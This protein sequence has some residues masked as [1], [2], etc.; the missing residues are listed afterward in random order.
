MTNLGLADT[1]KQFATGGGGMDVPVLTG[2]PPVGDFSGLMRLISQSTAP[3]AQNP[4]L[5]SPTSAI[6]Q[7]PNKFQAGMLDAFAPNE[8]QFITK[9]L[10]GQGYTQDA[11]GKFIPPPGSNLSD[12]DWEQGLLNA[13]ARFRAANPNAAGTAGQ[14]TSNIENSLT[15]F[16]Q[17][18]DAAKSAAME[19]FLQTIQD[20]SLFGTDTLFPNKQLLTALEEREAERVQTPFARFAG[21]PDQGAG[22]VA[23]SGPQILT[24]SEAT[25]AAQSRS[26]ESQTGVF[27]EQSEYAL[28]VTLGLERAIF[29][30]AG[31][32]GGTA[33]TPEGTP[34]LGRVTV[35]DVVTTDINPIDAQMR[36]VTG[37]VGQ[38]VGAVLG[39]VYGAGKGLVTGDARHLLAGIR[40]GINI[41][42]SVG[43]ALVPNDAWEV[44]LE[45]LP[46][47]GTV[48]GVSSALAKSALRASIAAYIAKNGVRG[49]TRD[50]IREIVF[51][52]TTALQQ[53]AV[54]HPSL[55]R[56]AQTLTEKGRGRGAVPLLRGAAATEDISGL[57][58]PALKLLARRL[59]AAAKTKGEGIVIPGAAK[60]KVEDLRTA[61]LKYAADPAAP[62]AGKLDIDELAKTIPSEDIADTTFTV[63]KVEFEGG[64]D[65]FVNNR[66][67]TRTQYEDAI[68]QGAEVKTLER[69]RGAGAGDGGKDNFIPDV[70]AITPADAGNQFVGDLS[71]FKEE[72]SEVVAGAPVA[73]RTMRGKAGNVISGATRQVA[74]RLG[75]NPS[76]LHGS[77][78]GRAVTAFYRQSLAAEQIIQTALGSALDVH[79]QSFSGRMVRAL[80]MNAD[81]LMT[82]SLKAGGG[83]VKRA[84]NDVFSQPD[85]YNLPESQLAF[86]RDYQQVVA[87]MESLRVA[88]GLEPLGLNKRDGWYYIPRQVDEVGGIKIPGR[89]NPHL[90]RTIENASDG[91]KAG[92]RYNADP[93]ST[94]ELHMKTSFQEI[95]EKEL[96]DNVAQFGV[97]PSALADKV[98]TL[99][100]KKAEMHMRRTKNAVA[101]ELLDL[102]RQLGA[103]G[104][105]RVKL[106]KQIDRL[107][108]T[109][110]PARNKA[111]KAEWEAAR[112]IRTRA[113]NTARRRKVAYKGK[114][115]RGI[116]DPAF[117]GNLGQRFSVRLWRGKFFP[118][119]DARL[120]NQALGHLSQ[121]SSGAWKALETS[122]NT[123]RFLSAVGDFAA[124]FIQGLPVL[125]SNPIAWSK[126]TAL[127]YQAFF[128]PSVQARIVRDNRKV[129]QEMARYGVPIG[130]PE[131]FRALERGGGPG[132]PGPLKRR[133]EKFTVGDTP[134]GREGIRA[135]QNVGK[136]TVGRFQASYNTFL[137]H[138]RALLWKNSKLP[139]AE[140]ARWIRNLTGG[141]DSR[142]LGVTAGQRSAESVWMAF[143]PR[144]LRSTVA[145]LLD[146]P[147]LNTA[148]G[149]AAFKSLA[150]TVAAAGGIYY[151]TGMA[152]GKTT[153]EILDG[154]NPLEGKKFMAHQVNGDWIGVGGQVRSILQLLTNIAA[155]PDGLLKGDVL[156]NP[157]FA[158]Y[159]SRGA[160]GTA[161]A[162]ATIEGV[163]GG[164]I[165]TLPFDDIDSLPDVGIHLFKSAAPFVIQG[166]MDGESAMSSAFGLAGLR[167]SGETPTEVLNRTLVAL[168]PESERTSGDGKTVWDEWKQLD[169]NQKN[170]A[171]ANHKEIGALLDER[172]EESDSRPTE[173]AEELKARRVE[174]FTD[175]QEN[176]DGQLYREQ[177]SRIGNDARIQFNEATLNQDDPEDF[178]EDQE[179]ITRYFTQVYDAV[180]Q[181]GG[182]EDYERLDQ[183]DAQF[184]ATLTPEEDALIDRQLGTSSDPNYQR[185]KAAR[186]YLDPYWGERDEIFNTFWQQ[187]GPAAVKSELSNYDDLVTASEDKTRSDFRELASLVSQM[188]QGLAPQLWNIRFG[189]ATTDALLYIYGYSDFVV[190]DDAKALVL[191]WGQ[192]NGV[193]FAVPPVR[194]R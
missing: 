172:R 96:S 47:V 28:E 141:L 175:F 137:G 49:L 126:A 53:A 67:A 138:S 143:S 121:Q 120:L 77:P 184:R 162:A 177:S 34:I 191:K 155:S 170:A 150:G 88:H 115:F 82:L 37:A 165:D 41:G 125:G 127:H 80:P 188:N 86:I 189:D 50:V 173:I 114:A 161:I 106:S 19:G 157:L 31:I 58:G 102:R 25:I 73:A 3:G 7:N 6:T 131:F 76:V 79:A 5:G 70:E 35:G 72:V 122:A 65:H 183:L 133:I 179:L 156:N 43:D 13:K 32:V 159:N 74:G 151:A 9:D 148:S 56:L 26:P 178:T 149:R 24:G 135:A 93:R 2:V 57:K 185:L 95:V 193:G 14:I 192:T 99:L 104:A 48:T 71:P 91:G 36:A 147:R 129:Y 68:S 144:L 30:S 187:N 60:M 142:A 51:Q 61:I 16:A 11:T 194:N 140:R 163:S 64:A 75:I 18:Q 12:A 112:K 117:K 94:L 20:P 116:N 110:G 21:A 118:Q 17:N 40:D 55:N 81:G 42:D 111:A 153:E 100:A 22:N 186:A 78:I 33:L 174:I 139:P 146:A 97:K 105:D 63:T 92:V 119:E 103:Q 87:E 124:P 154:L 66:P 190:S 160:V 44:A 10:L 27:A 182:P 152:L 23:R 168:V 90:L 109:S 29:T 108:S 83:N 38:G 171:E 85:L 1:K 130:D 45:F 8:G 62:P 145:L 46:G 15:G 176:G 167:T 134:V 180:G 69:P 132:I 54:K 59:N 107:V 164:E 52:T 136:Q 84:W 39:G 89:T 158:F 101:K 128:D 98:S 113:M 169:K 4:F 181:L 123:I 166:I